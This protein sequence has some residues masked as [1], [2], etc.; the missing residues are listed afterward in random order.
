MSQPHD[1]T[2]VRSTQVIVF[3]QPHIPT[4][5]SRGPSHP[6]SE[7]PHLQPIIC[8]CYVQGQ[9]SE[10]FPPHSGEVTA[11]RKPG[12]LCRKSK[13]RLAVRRIS[14][15]K[16]GR[17]TRSVLFIGAI[18]GMPANSEQAL[19]Y[20]ENQSEF[21]LKMCG[22]ENKTITIKIPNARPE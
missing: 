4:L 19:F 22:S 8:P 1:N 5:S 18:L 14:V 3:V 7:G 10:A 13:V 15:K 17:L 20:W 11:K 21:V 9:D 12:Y 16:W 2:C 6:P